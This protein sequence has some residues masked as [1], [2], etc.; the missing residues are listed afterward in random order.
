MDRKLWTED[1]LREYVEKIFEEYKKLEDRCVFL[2]DENRRLRMENEKWYEESLKWEAKA[3]D[4]GLFSRLFSK[5]KDMPDMGN[6]NPF[7]SEALLDELEKNPSPKGALIEGLELRKVKEVPGLFIEYLQEE[8]TKEEVLGLLD[9]HMPNNDPQML[10]VVMGL[11]GD[12][13]LYEFL[14]Q[15][16]EIYPFF[17][18][19]AMDFTT[20]WRICKHFYLMEDKDVERQVQSLL[21]SLLQSREFQLL[22]SKER[23]IFAEMSV[24]VFDMRKVEEIGPFLRFLKKEEWE[25][26]KDYISSFH[27]PENK[28]KI[29]LDIEARSWDLREDSYTS[30]VK[31]KIYKEYKKKIE[32]DHSSPR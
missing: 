25:F 6:T 28:Q 32:T 13:M 16:E 29:L 14:N 18:N 31:R 11:L 4:G 5:K 9:E 30:A 8:P 20:Q 1:D 10:N 12:E 19:K 15:H 7:D 2:E 22:P 26:L 27:H 3:K 17:R 24:A 23:E 21:Q